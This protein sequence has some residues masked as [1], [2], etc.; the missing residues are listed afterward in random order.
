[1]NAPKTRS[2]VRRLVAP[3]AA[4][5]AGLMVLAWSAAAWA[6]PPVWIVK[7]KDSEILLF[8]SIHILP[9]GLDWQPPALVQALKRA[10][11]LWFE[12][13]IDAQSEAETAEL[14]IQAGALP[15]ADSLFRKLP[16]PDSALMAKVA[17]DYGI[18][19]MLL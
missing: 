14:A 6:L 2:G 18:S 16:A 10:D 7:D 9:P 12:L 11:D 15:P 3:L 4:S 8:G 5:L 17:Q 1:M 13:P 19:P